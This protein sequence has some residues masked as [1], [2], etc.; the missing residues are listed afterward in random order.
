MEQEATFRLVILV[1][2]LLVFPAGLVYRVRSQRT[3]ERLDRWQEGP[4]ILFPLRIAAAAALIG[5]VAYL[6]DPLSMAWSAMPLPLWVRWSGAAFAAAGGVLLLWAFH[7]LGPNLTDTVVTRRAHTLVTRGPYRWV[8]HPFYDAVMLL[9]LGT[10][11][12]TANW[13]IL[14][15]GVAA[16]SLM[17]ARTRI[18]EEHL[19]ARFGDAYLLYTAR[20]GR[21]L[22]KRSADAG[23]GQHV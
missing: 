18:E 19:R 9:T 17:V 8:R 15:A 16:V 11:L 13:F 7:T 3:R 6:R 22:P 1:G 23:E 14:T 12:L 21:F 5:T 2:A 20:T 10:S 4:F